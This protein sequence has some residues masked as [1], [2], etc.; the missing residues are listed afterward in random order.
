[1]QQRA[2]VEHQPHLRPAVASQFTVPLGTP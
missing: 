2:E 1:V